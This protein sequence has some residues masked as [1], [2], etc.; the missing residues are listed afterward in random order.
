MNKKRWGTLLL[1]GLLM[2]PLASCGGGG[3]SSASSSEPGSASLPEEPSVSV[4]AP[5][6][7]PEP[8]HINPLTGEEAEEGFDGEGCWCREAPDEEAAQLLPRCH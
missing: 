5:V 4:I 3:K 2:V 7:D 6:E 1:A 8:L